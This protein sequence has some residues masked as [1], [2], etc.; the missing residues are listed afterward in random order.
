MWRN[1]IDLHSYFLKY[2][3]FA[4]ATKVQILMLVISSLGD[5]GKSKNFFLKNED[6]SS[7][8]GAMLTLALD[9]W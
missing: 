6:I 1:V 5:K 4:I 7:F 8:V 3:Y 9:L 2:F